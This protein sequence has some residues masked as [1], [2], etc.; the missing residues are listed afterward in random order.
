M[1][2]IKFWKT[3]FK[4]IE[5]VWSAVPLESFEMLSSTNFTWSTLEYFVSCLLVIYTR[6]KRV[7]NKAWSKRGDGQFGHRL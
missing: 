4:K 7:I 2:Q 6:P 3:D 5:G 1:D